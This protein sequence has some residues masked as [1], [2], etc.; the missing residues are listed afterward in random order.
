M[1]KKLLIPVVL[2]AGAAA[3]YVI[4]RSNG[5]EDANRIVLSGNVELTQV[6]VGFKTA[7]Q[8]QEIAVREGDT[9]REG[10]TLARLDRKQ[11]LQQ[12]AAAE[13]AL[14]AAR[15]Q[16][17]QANTALEW[18]RRTLAGDLEA[19]QAELE[20]MQARL[21]EL[22]TGSRPQEIREAEAAVAAAR[23]EFERASRDWERAQQL[24]KNEDISTAQYDQFRAREN[25]SG[26]AL[27]QAEQRLALVRE[28]PRKETIAAAEAQVARARA[29]LE[30]G[31]ANELETRRREQ[32]LTARRAEIERLQAQ[33]GLIDE[34]LQ[35]TV[36]TSP[37]NGVVLVKSADTGE[38]IAPG[39]TILTLGDVG[40]PWIRGYI[41]ES[42]L[43]RVKL[44]QKVRVTT[45]S[46]PGKDY[47]GRVTF[48]S[49]EAEFTPKQIQTEQERV[50]LVY[51]I[52]VEVDNPHGELKLNMPADAE[53]PLG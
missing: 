14:A 13:A 24:Y 29:A 4:I 17:A 2:L 41:N 36:A 7:G 25:A 47:W 43:G 31:R 32:E 18:Q 34:Q 27:K 40:H 51:R 39:A 5:E 50:K 8:I 19:R 35:D 21:Q 44:G 11:L 42:D 48:I 12:K 30:V 3:A 26:A 9:V 52:K 6:N 49:S 1:K 16:L 45:D 23:T 33:I 46:Y 15:A 22:E 10:Q 20:A 28:G 37:I 38:I 53:I